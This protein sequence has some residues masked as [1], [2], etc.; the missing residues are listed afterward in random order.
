MGTI[1]DIREGVNSGAW[2][3]G[4]ITGSNELGVT[5]EEYS[6]MA[7]DE[8]TPLK[9]EVKERMLSAG[10]HYVLDTIRELPVCINEINRIMA[11]NA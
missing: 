10:A 6:R 9:R 8:R 7:D 4:I 3:V 11:V 5:L 1:A 2:S